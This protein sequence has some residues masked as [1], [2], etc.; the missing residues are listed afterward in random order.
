MKTYEQEVDELR[1]HIENIVTLA[2]GGF[3]SGDA[4]EIKKGKA[5]LH[6]R[7]LGRKSFILA[8]LIAEEGPD[9]S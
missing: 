1:K 7:G 5:I 6:L 8:K 4:A 2:A 3:G 9:G